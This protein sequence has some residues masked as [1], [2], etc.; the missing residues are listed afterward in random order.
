MQLY[1]VLEGIQVW[2][3][4][5]HVEDMWSNPNELSE[6]MNKL[7]VYNSYL[8]EHIAPLHKK[9]TETEILAYKRERQNNVKLG[10]SS[11]S[12]KLEG[13]ES[14]HDY[15]HVK[16]VNKSVSDLTNVIQSRLKVL[17]EQARSNI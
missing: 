16:L 11:M 12:A 7:A 6:A 4:K 1:K 15:E 14:R 5:L 17:S 10:D 9:A 2:R 13:L 3:E 8:A